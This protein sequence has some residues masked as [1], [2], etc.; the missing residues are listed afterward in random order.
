MNSKKQ[1][2]DKSGLSSNRFLSK[3]KSK[4]VKIKK[5]EKSIT[6]ISTPAISQ[7]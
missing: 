4:V 1:L 6:F 5:S 7:G 2:K 3:I